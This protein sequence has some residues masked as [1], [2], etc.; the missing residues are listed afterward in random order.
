MNT[1]QVAYI[2]SL[3]DRFTGTMKKVDNSTQNFEK[4]VGGLKSA[5]MNMFVGI[6]IYR[7]GKAFLTLGANMEQTRVAFSTFMGDTEK[8]NKLIAEL[9]Q[10]AN[11]T[12]FNNEEVI[13]SGRVLL[14][15]QVPAEKMIETMKAVGDVAA[16]SNVPLNEMASIYAKSMNKGKIQAEELNQ[17]AERGV[18]ILQTFAKMYNKTTAEIME[19]GSKGQLTSASL[20]EAFRVMTTEG[21][22]FNNMMKKQSETVGGKWSTLVG[23]FQLKMLELSEK[24]MPGVA[25]ALEWVIA[26]L[27]GIIQAVI[28]GVKM[29]AAYSITVKYIVPAIQWA[30]SAFKALRAGTLSLNSAMAKN[31][32]GAVAAGLVILIPEIYSAITA[33]SLLEDAEEDIT[34]KF[35]DQ[36]AELEVLRL[37]LMTTK[38]GTQQYNDVIDELNEKTKDLTGVNLDYASSEK[39]IAQAIDL[40]NAAMKRKISV[41]IYQEKLKEAIKMQMELQDRIREGS[42]DWTDPVAVKAAEDQIGKIQ[43]RIAKLQG[44]QANA[45]IGINTPENPV[46]GLTADAIEIDEETKKNL[47]KATK[48]TSGAPKVFNININQLVGEITNSFTNVKDSI[49]DMEK[50]VTEALVKAINDAQ[51]IANV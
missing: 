16:G 37:Q 44:E 22:M 14:A 31:V 46:N 29:W 43:N 4:R 11:I 6:G 18:P 9:N 40:A 5:M 19:M 13:K 45:T 47:D 23:Q 27:D 41:E 34:D 10:F 21:G 7:A 28:T 17:L 38:K 8:A 2:I 33:T 20:T 25:K 3:Q 1:D 39:D 30:T 12:P 49:V 51:I 48:I 35:I 42:G 24:I 26:N 32:L 36:K 50:Q 15:A